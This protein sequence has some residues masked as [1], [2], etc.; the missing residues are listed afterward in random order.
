MKRSLVSA[1]LFFGAHTAQAQTLSGS[2]VFWG[3]S[4]DVLV[5]SPV[6]PNRID[7]LA[8]N[9]DCSLFNLAMCDALEVANTPTGGSEIS[10]TL[11]ENST[12]PTGL[13][14]NTTMY[15]WWQTGGGGNCLYNTTTPQS[16]TILLTSEPLTTDLVVGGNSTLNYPGDFAAV[17]HITIGQVLNTWNGATGGASSMAGHSFCPSTGTTPQAPV[18][19][20]ILQLCFGFDTSGTGAGVT[21]SSPTAWVEFYVDTTV[22]S[23]T[24]ALDVTPQDSN[25]AIKITPT[26]GTDSD[27]YWWAFFA[28]L[29]D[30]VGSAIP[31][32]SAWQSANVQLASRG[33][34]ASASLPAINW[35]NYKVWVCPVDFTGNTPTDLTLANTTQYVLAT[36]AQPTFQ[37][38][39][40]DCYPGNLKTGFCGAGEAPSGLFLLAAVGTL[41]LVVRRG[42]KKKRAAPMPRL[43]ALA[44][45]GLTWGIPGLVRAQA[46][47]SSDVPTWEIEVQTGPYRPKVSGNAIVRDYYKLTYPSDGSMFKGMPLLTVIQGDWYLLRD[48]GL[49][50]VSFAAGYWKVSGTARSCY[51]GTGATQQAVPCTAQTVFESVP[52]NTVTSLT[53]IPLSVGVQYRYDWLK[54][55]LHVPLVPYAKAGLDYWI[56]FNDK[57]GSL[58]HNAAGAAG[59]GATWGFHGAAGLALNLDWLDPSSGSLGAKSDFTGVYLFGEYS[60]YIANDFG[61]TDR[62]DASANIVWVGLSLDLR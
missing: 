36:D 58:S 12:S 48:Y 13:P 27:V 25:L 29:D 15:V 60:T 54:R 37:C 23:P 57:G 7:C 52:G 43:A 46:S 40:I 34:A 17:P 33:V 5:N 31:S 50:G 53:M 6:A 41:W 30:P 61:K 22:P 28:Q 44:L 14:V 56:W 62:L 45:C 10:V 47:Q 11:S 59:D 4:Y 35:Q 39:F 9:I 16:N 42:P 21:S 3:G 20:T 32:C 1:L 26:V 19:L 2:V 51:V 49:L 8:S 24:V 55:S 38:D 18:P